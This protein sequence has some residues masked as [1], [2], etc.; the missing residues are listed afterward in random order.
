MW[1]RLTMLYSNTNNKSRV[2]D[3]LKKLFQLNQEEQSIQEFYTEFQALFDEL[4]LLGPIPTSPAEM[5]A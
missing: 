1:N 4:D 3:V 5:I 2:C